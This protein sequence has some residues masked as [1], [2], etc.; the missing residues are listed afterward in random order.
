M[1]I[2][3][4]IKKLEERSNSG[5]LVV[6][7]E[8]EYQGEQCGSAV[9]CVDDM[10]VYQTERLADESTDK[11]KLRFVR[12]YRESIEEQLSLAGNTVVVLSADVR[13]L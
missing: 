9:A 13:D 7:P 2:K 4:R 10:P 6:T 3:T 1:R 11:F 5:F 8:V 12:E